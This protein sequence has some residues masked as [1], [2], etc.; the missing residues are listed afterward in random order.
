MRSILDNLD[1]LGDGVQV[2]EFSLVV[3]HFGDLCMSSRGKLVR[4]VVVERS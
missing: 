4:F 1:D 3:L 2:N